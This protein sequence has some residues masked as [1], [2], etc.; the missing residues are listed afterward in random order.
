MAL[1]KKAAGQGHAYAMH[2][3]GSFHHERNE[4]EQAVGWFTKGAEAGLPNAMFDLG[5]ALDNGKGVAAL[6]SPAAADWYRRAA[7]AGVGDAAANLSVMYT[8]GCGRAW[9]IMYTLRHIS[10]L[11]FLS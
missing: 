10:V 4:H 5:Y 11:R 3:L 7:D 1:L 6:D 9:Q 2:A 8:L